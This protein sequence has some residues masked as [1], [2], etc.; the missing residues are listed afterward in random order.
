MRVHLLIIVLSFISLK[1][2]AVHDTAIL[3]ATA[4]A[5]FAVS[6]AHSD[7]PELEEKIYLIIGVFA[8]KN[9]AEAFTAD[10]RSKGYHPAFALNPLNNLY[11]VYLQSTHQ[12]D[13][14]KQGWEKAMEDPTLFPG[15]WILNYK[16][17]ATE[18]SAPSQLADIDEVK[19]L[20]PMPVQAAAPEVIIEKENQPLKEHEYLIFPKTLYA[21]NSKPIQGKVEVVDP[22][23][24]KLI[25]NINANELS[26]VPDPKNGSH[27]IQLTADIFG[28]RKVQHDLALIMLEGETPSD[29]IF[30]Q[31]DTIL[32]E[33]LLERLK[34]GDIATMYN[35]FFRNE[36]AIMESTSQYELN[37]LLEMLKENPDYRIVIHGHANGNKSGKI[38][39]LTEENP[40]FFTI[41]EENKRGWGSAKK[42]SEARATTIK[43]YLEA[44][45]IEGS[46][47]VVKGWG[48]KKMIYDYNSLDAKKNVRVEIE[49]IQD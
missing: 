22:I 38:I 29:Y 48:G 44:N 30:L 40:D 10:T 2:W 5:Q 24:V 27:L 49:I 47:M 15:V 9:N 45:G 39:M 14:A 4:V 3:D 8:Y 16:K 21:R 32:V 25:K 18:A 28:Y 19:D 42:L 41:S 33:F 1:G 12:M 11:Y 31:G 36:A 20:D 6:T 35:V 37:G 17:A 34:T 43:R 23:R 46:R 7:L 26:K 13:E